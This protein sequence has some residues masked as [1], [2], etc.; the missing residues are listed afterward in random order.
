[1]FI[2]LSALLFLASPYPFEIKTGVT[3][4]P[5]AGSALADKHD[6]VSLASGLRLT[7]LYFDESDALITGEIQGGV[8][9]VF[10]ND[11]NKA[12]YK[13]MGTGGITF[14][15]LFN[16]VAIRLTLGGGTEYRKSSFNPEI[17]ARLGLGR[18]FTSRFGAFIDGAYYDIY[19]KL[20]QAGPAGTTLHARQW[21][22]VIELTLSMQWIF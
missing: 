3:L 21:Q 4:E 1:M 17:F 15:E 10:A 6:D 18:Y 22:Q 19:R 9:T 11:G 12:F 2:T 20:S 8:Q 16:P 7:Y 14:Y 13:W 5:Y